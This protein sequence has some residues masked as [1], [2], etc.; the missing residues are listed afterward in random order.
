MLSSTEH[1]GRAGGP[2]ACG[3]LFNVSPQ[4]GGRGVSRSWDAISTSHPPRGEAQV[5]CVSGEPQGREALC[6]G[7]AEDAGLHTILSW[8]LSSVPAA[9]M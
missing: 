2:E 7:T 3:G 5:S 8:M 9:P 6:L 4:H 1:T